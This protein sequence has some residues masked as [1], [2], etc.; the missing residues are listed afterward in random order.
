[1]QGDAPE[2][3]GEPLLPVEKSKI[4]K[5]YMAPPCQ[6]KKSKQIEQILDAHVYPASGL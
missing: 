4:R 6:T 2:I 5:P 1:V 3:L